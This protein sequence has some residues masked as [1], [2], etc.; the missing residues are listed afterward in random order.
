MP[1]TLR[2]LV[3]A[4]LTLAAACGDGGPTSTIPL[5]APSG[6]TATATSANTVHLSFS[7]VPG[8]KGYIIRRATE[9]GDFAEV[10]RAADAA[11]DDGGLEPSSTYRYEV[12]AFRGDESG[13]A[14]DRVSV[15]TRAAGEKQA[16]LSGSITTSRTLTAD[17]V[18]VL[19]GTV[20]VRDGATLTIHP[21]TRI[22]GDLAVPGSSL[23]I[24]RGAKIMAEGTAANPIVFT[25]QRDEGHR[26]PGDWGGISIVGNATTNL[27][28]GVHTE[29]SG[30]TTPY[31]GGNNDADNSGILRYVRIEFAGYAIL[32][33]LEM[34]SLSLYAVGRGTTIDHVEVLMGLDDSFKW[35]GG[36]VDG[37]YLVS[38]EASDD[39]FDISQGY[40]GRNQFLIALQTRVLGGYPGS[41]Q[42]AYD[43]EAFES[44][45]CE[46]EV[47][48]CGGDFTRAPYTVPVFANFTAIG[49]G[50]AS[51]DENKGLVIRRG[52]AGVWV[53]G[54]IARF[55][56]GAL[57]VRDAFTDE[58]RT[59]DSLALSHLLF[60]ENGSNFEPDG[61]NYGQR[62]RFASSDIEE[63]GASAASLFV[64]LPSDPT[65]AT[66]DWTPAPG[67]PAASG[68]LTSFSGRLAA[69]AGGV[70]VPTSYRGAADPSG[71]KWWQ[72]W[73]VY[74][75]D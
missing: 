57:S 48:A 72:G 8:A 61:V 65:T 42:P 15:T 37:K 67:S 66:L 32:P 70:I 6:L 3:T 25:S 11:F 5:V 46:A 49:F 58:L 35:F 31:T 63:S 73:T 36:T 28:G 43:N 24:V 13:P 47:G 23:L 1:P 10:G 40:R 17:T 62:S 54:I 22:V 21:G 16:V 44:D 41:G 74:R 9:T 55:R 45:G 4:L 39:H 68:G 19:S 33:D 52:S 51:S 59:R 64:S 2:I 14:S 20:Q 38:Y 26:A 27:P 7:A 18:Y 30:G 50:G 75:R 71:P 53:N 12:A 60:A 29:G 69:R 56:D 34:N